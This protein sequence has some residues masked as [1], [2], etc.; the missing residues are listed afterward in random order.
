MARVLFYVQHLLGVG[1]VKR[2]AAIAR[3]MAA[4]DRGTGLRQHDVHMVLGGEAVQHVDF[5]AAATMQLPE[6]RAADAG[7]SQ[8]LDAHGRPIDQTWKAARTAQLLGI[9]EDVQPE[10]ILLE[11]YPFG[12][13]AFRFELDPLLA[14]WRPRAKV[15]ASVRDVLVERDDPQ[16][17][18]RV[19]ALVRGQVDRVLVHGDEAVIPFAATFPRA[20]ELA[21]LIRYT[22]YVVDGTPAGHAAPALLD[23]EPGEVVVSV[24]GGAVGEGLLQ[25]AVEA[26]LSGALKPRRW[27]LLAGRN[28]GEPVFARLAAQLPAGGPVVLEWARPDFR[29]VLARAAL[30]ISQGGYNTLMDILVA[31][32]P[33]LI[34]PFMAGAESEQLFRAREFERLGRITVLPETE[35]SPRTLAATAERAIQQ[36]VTA[37][38]IAHDGARRTAALVAELAGGC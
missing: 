35:L 10:V 26:A 37:V 12:R 4:P 18:A 5:G 8:I 32:C 14:A 33:A 13:R 15:A 2:A 1:H 7:F 23:A 11:H 21:D 17:S 6:A 16:K 34:V 9:A 31:G 36:P 25:A 38:S 24:G 30:S 22:G 3:A 27:R 19:V 28:L 20:A 29:E